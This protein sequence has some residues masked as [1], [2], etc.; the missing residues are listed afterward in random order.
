[1][2]FRDRQH[3]S[4][5]LARTDTQ[6]CPFARTNYFYKSFVPSICNIATW[7]SLD[8]SQVCTTTLSSFKWLLY[9]SF[10]PW[11][12]ARLAYA[13]VYPLLRVYRLKS[14]KCQI[15]HEHMEA[16]GCNFSPHLWHSASA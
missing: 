7:N 4:E 5:R 13:I 14:R 2:Y 9:F 1:M 6:G 12:H 10:I 8:D 11:V 16:K 3:T 15:I